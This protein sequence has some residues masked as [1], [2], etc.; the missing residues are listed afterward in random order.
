MKPVECAGYGVSLTL[1]QCLENQL[2]PYCL[3]GWPCETCEE[4]VGIV[5]KG[6]SFHCV[7]LGVKVSQGLCDAARVEA[8][9]RQKV[10]P[11]GMGW[12]ECCCDCDIY[13]KVG[14][15]GRDPAVM[16]SSFP[17]HGGAPALKKPQPQ[18][19]RRPAWWQNAS[20]AVQRD[21]L[22]DHEGRQ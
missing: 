10:W 19:K 11:E 13:A 15:P 6:K 12:L 2:S 22:R 20:K 8:Q 16:K 7:H 14:R 3:P 1:W 21:W 18:P 9:R 4:A 17:D 5:V